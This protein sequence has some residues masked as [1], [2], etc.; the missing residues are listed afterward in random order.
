M[1]AV[2]GGVIED[3]LAQNEQIANLSITGMISTNKK[4]KIGEE[5]KRKAEKGRSRKFY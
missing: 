1:A 2:V 5:T 4:K 3:R